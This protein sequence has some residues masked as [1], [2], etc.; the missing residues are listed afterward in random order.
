MSNKTTLYQKARTGKT[1]FIT[2]SVV[3]DRLITEWGLVGGK[4]QKTEKVCKPTNVGRAN[5]LDGHQQALAELKSKLEDKL[6]SGYDTEL[7]S[8]VTSLTAR[9]FDKHLP[10]NFCPPKPISNAPLSV[11]NNAATYAQRKHDGHCVI[12]VR[13]KK[14]SKM[15]TRRIEDR[16]ISM[17][18]FPVVQAQMDLLADQ[19]LVLAELAYERKATQKEVA[20]EIQRI[21]GPDSSS[22]AA[23]RYTALTATG[24]FIC[25]PFDVL[26]YKGK[27]VGD[28]DYRERYAML[29]DMGLDVPK[30]IKDWR[31]YEETA[32]ALGWEGFILRVPGDHSHVEY[33]MD[34]KARRVGSYKYKFTKTDDFIVTEALLGKSG[35][36]ASLYCKF[37]LSQ[38]DAAGRSID[39]AYVGGGT[40]THDQLAELT[41]EIKS[42]ARKFPFVVEVEYQTFHEDSGAIQFGQILRLRDDKRPSE[43]I[44]EG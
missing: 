24:T 14:T 34:G 17:S 39:R 30:I 15:Y 16:S 2:L 41:A 42:G 33:T 20:T 23:S 18:R 38:L 1:K 44:Y 37:K 25:K 5:E 26:F 36:H 21:L 9:D 12:L 35:K 19:T 43:C 11:L 27:F 7:G 22:E 29:T 31:N 8:A 28:H 4:S 6:G 40:L 32:K 10:E 3:G 13:G